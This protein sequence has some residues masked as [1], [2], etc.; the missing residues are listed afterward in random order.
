MLATLGEEVQRFIAT[1]SVGSRLTTL[2]Y[3]SKALSALIY[4]T[5]NTSAGHLIINQVP[6]QIGF[7]CLYYVIW[8]LALF[9][10]WIRL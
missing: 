7:I 5:F 10:S 4:V 6:W 1:F 9:F 2:K 3:I 8:V